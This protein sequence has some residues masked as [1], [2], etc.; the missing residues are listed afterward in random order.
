MMDKAAQTSADAILL[1]LEDAVPEQEKVAARAMVRTY[2][3][4]LVRRHVFVRINAVSTAVARRDLEVIVARGLDGVFLPKVESPEDV[5]IVAGWLDMLEV[6]A[7]LVHGSIELI[8]MLESA[9]GVRLS[10]E[11]GS[12][13]ERVT[14]LLFASGENGDFQA[15][16]R[17]DWSVGGPELLY[18]RS[19]VVLD[20]RAAGL[21]YVLDGVFVDIDN[22]DNLIADTT[23]SKR[24][25]YTGRTIVHPKHIDHV[26]RIYSP[27]DEEVSYYRELLSAF[28][29]ALAIGHASVTFRGKM[30]DYAMARRARQVLERREMIRSLQT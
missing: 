24:L 15:D 20:S 19:K 25:G 23:V 6:T 10:F 9:R 5:R 3:D 4:S 17:C 11:I 21:D 1:D 13:S 30:I 7:G 2:I 29:A 8:C 22:I 28:D 16:M 14:A 18:A 27:S 26:N 12:S